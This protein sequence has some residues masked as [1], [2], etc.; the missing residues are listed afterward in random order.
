[1][2]FRMRVWLDELE[3]LP[4]YSHSNPTGTCPGKTWKRKYADGTWV[5]MQYG[6]IHGNWIDTFR[7]EVV[8]RQG[9]RRNR[10]EPLPFKISCSWKEL[11]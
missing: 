10:E 8:L 11:Q 1:M 5:I 9:P 4:E 2:P 3:R 7:F 6:A